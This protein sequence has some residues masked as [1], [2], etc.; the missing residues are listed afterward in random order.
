MVG[1]NDNAL[2]FEWQLKAQACELLALSFRYP[3]ETLVEAVSSGE[4]NQAAAEIWGALGLALPDGWDEGLGEVDIHD[5]RAEATRLFVG[6]PKPSVCNLYEG[7]WRAKDDGVQPLMFVNPHSMAVERFCKSCGLGRSEGAN[8][9]LDNLATECELLQYLASLEAGIAS[10]VEGGPS[11]EELPGGS[12]GAAY[13]TF[14]E[15]HFLT[16]APR[17]AK[18]VESESRIA[19]YRAAARLLSAFCGQQE[20]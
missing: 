11:L 12:A 13:E 7:F 19:L 1:S 20:S 17:L 3:D 4:W 9:P 5:V 10:S 8:D 18:K 2:V 15:E 14:M 6:G 16:F